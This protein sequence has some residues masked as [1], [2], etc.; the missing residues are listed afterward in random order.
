MH[1]VIFILAYIL[2]ITEFILSCPTRTFSHDFIISHESC[3]STQ[4]GEIGAAVVIEKKQRL[5]L[6]L[7]PTI[8][9][10]VQVSQA[11]MVLSA[12]AA[13]VTSASWCTDARPQWC[14]A[15]LVN[16][17]GAWTW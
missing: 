5:M 8:M 13:A 10:V 1:S 14:Y 17:S 11:T 7:L 12:A 2:P 6:S 3:V 16:V 9:I 4:A 15:L